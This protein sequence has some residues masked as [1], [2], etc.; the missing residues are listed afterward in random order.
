M[1][2]KEIVQLAVKKAIRCREAKEVLEKIY[3]TKKMQE[4]KEGKYNL[5]KEIK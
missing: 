2:N 5:Y 3:W 4:V 1:R